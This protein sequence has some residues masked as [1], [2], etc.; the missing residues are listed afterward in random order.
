M[1]LVEL[2]LQTNNV[3]VPTVS[4]VYGIGGRDTT[5]NQI[6]SVYTDLKEIAESG[7]FENPYRYLGLR[8][9]EK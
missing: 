1:E 7:K 8:K 6:E 5:S 3:Q 9:E 4:Y 2:Y